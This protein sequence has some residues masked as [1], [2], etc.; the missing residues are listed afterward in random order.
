MTIIK[1]LQQRQQVIWD[2]PQVEQQPTTFLFYARLS[3][4][5][6]DKWY[7]RVTTYV[8]RATWTPVQGISFRKTR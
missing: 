1:Q 5:K 8:A 7:H 2:N 3:G 6:R 4:N